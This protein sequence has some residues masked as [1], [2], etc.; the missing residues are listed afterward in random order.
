MNTHQYLTA[1]R[2]YWYVIVVATIVGGLAGFGLSQIAK[3]VYTATS[4]L[5]FSLN[6]GGSASDLS[7]GSTY[8]QNQMLSFAQLAESPVVL[9]PVVDD[10]DL[11]VTAKGLAD[12][13][14]VSTPQNT[15]ILEL[16]VTD[17]DPAQAA[18]IANAVAASLSKTVEQI[19][20]KN[21]EGQTTVSVRV[22]ENASEPKD[23]SSPNTR[24]N[25]VTGLL[26]GLIVGVLILVL[27]ATLDTRVHSAEIAAAVTQAPLLGSIQKERGKHPRPVLAVEP[28]SNS[29][30]N[31]RQLRSNLEFVT[32]GS[33]SRGIVVT[34]SIPAEGKSMIAT[35]L[36][37]ALAETGQ[38]AL[39]I[40]ADLR[41]PMVANYSGLVGDAG[42]TSVLAGRAEFSDVVQRW[43]EGSLDVLTSGPIP[44]NPS[45]L[46]SSRAM[47]ELLGRLVADY[48]V[49]VIDTAPLIAVADAAILARQVGGAIVVVD[50][51]HVRRQQLTQT[52]D[53]LEKSGVTVL[54]IVLNRVSA[55]KNRD[56][57]Y[58]AAKQPQRRFGLP[59][60]ASSTAAGTAAAPDDADSAESSES[61]PTHK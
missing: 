41:R 16:A 44:P 5:Y 43:G 33:P 19:A 57:Y 59:T 3:P 52:M 11:D 20:P 47:T 15:V 36:A 8:T 54:G 56:V 32:L 48:D 37:L 23:P 35:N 42:L 50:R 24:L 1:F 22:I 7:Q 25:V 53:S 13:I 10:L 55:Q 60:R 34:S 12:A 45:E 40:D 4:G 31:Y 51:T 26:L 58:P 39:L 9:Q 49:V 46:L 6:F 17:P 61:V 30:E 21:A 29:A 38:R 14:A 18:K 28:L 2:R 27:R